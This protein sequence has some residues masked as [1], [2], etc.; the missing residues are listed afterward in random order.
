M[1][2]YG[3]SVE[4]EISVKK[5][6]IVSRFLIKIDI[7]KLDLET[8]WMDIVVEEGLDIT[9]DMMDRVLMDQS[10]DISQRS[11][12][13]NNMMDHAVVS[14]DSIEEELEDVNFR[15]TMET[16][17]NTNDFDLFIYYPP[18][19]SHLYTLLFTQ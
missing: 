3:D 6:D 13:D 1:E 11:I 2:M 7:K 16:I 8:V 9:E 17:L 18:I 19:R 10:M 14:V 4:I 12:E 15:T 5:M